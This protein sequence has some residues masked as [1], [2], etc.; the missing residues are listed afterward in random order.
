MDV[1]KQHELLDSVEVQT[2]IGDG[3]ALAIERMRTSEVA[4]RIVI[5]LSDGESNAGLIEPE[6]AA[7]IALGQWPMSLINP[8]VR[9]TVPAREWPKEWTVI[10]AEAGK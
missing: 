1:P 7:R 6:E 4:S 5:L 10:V 9:S 8:D 3:L 2:A